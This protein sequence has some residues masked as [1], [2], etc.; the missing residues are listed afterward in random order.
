MIP[1]V[2]FLFLINSKIVWIEFW[3]NYRINKMVFIVKYHFYNSQTIQKKN[4]QLFIMFC[5]LFFIH[6][7]LYSIF[8]F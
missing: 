1:L 6:K 5:E 4:L 8:L 2:L 7:I 3:Q